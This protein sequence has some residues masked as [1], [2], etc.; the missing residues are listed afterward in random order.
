MISGKRTEPAAARRRILGKPGLELVEE[1]VYLLRQTPLATLALYFIGSLPFVFGVITFWAAMIQS[2]YAWQTL[3]DAA[4][5]LALLFVWMKVWQSRFCQHLMAQLQGDRVPR[6][7]PGCFLRSVSIQGL[8]Q[9]TG[10]IVLPVAA[11]L[12][13]PFG[14]VYAAYQNATVLDSG[15]Y[16]STRSLLRDA[17]AQARLWPRQNHVVIWLLSPFLLLLV[18]GVFLGLLP[19]INALSSIFLTSVLYLLAGILILALMPLSPFGLIVALNLGT[20][21]LF[22]VGLLDTLLGIK[23][24]FSTVPGAAL[25]S[26]FVAMVFGLAYLC[27]D[28][29]V[30]A[31]Y[32]LRCFYSDSLK[33]G[34]DLRVALRRYGNVSNTRGSV[35]HTPNRRYGSLLLLAVFGVALA[36]VMRSGGDVKAASEWRVAPEQIDRALDQELTHRR[37]TWRMP[38]QNI[39]RDDGL[40]RPILLR[41]KKKLYGYAEVIG[42]WLGKRFRSWFTPSPE[43]IAKTFRA[44]AAAAP[45][46]RWLLILLLVSLVAAF[47]LLTVRLWRQRRRAEPRLGEAMLPAA[48]DLED[49]KT[50]AADLPE[51]EWV[52]MAREL[53]G[54]GEYRLAI[55]ALHLAS[56]ARLAET[57]YLRLA[58][59]K[60]NAEYL[61]ELK[62]RAHSRPDVIPAFSGSTQI[63]EAVWY[64]GHDPAERMLHERMLSNL[65]Q[66]EPGA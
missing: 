9:A 63:Y 53:I 47:A 33:S 20:G 34:E 27:M 24:V 57:G 30:K 1:A 11:L 45:L 58:R 12:T 2:A 26:T 19:V 43:G 22:S 65:A 40:V 21:I 4:L 15:E 7:T 17:V 59:Y 5:G 8:F 55:R 25:N 49:E 6:W 28:P 16:L 14:W 61:R 48:P 36:A 44:L 10:F 23:T 41:I 35:S 32:V 62:R 3:P 31:A 42:R 60:S 39:E 13:I 66:L 56:L 46:L 51:E 18:A 37:Y 52:A 64:G 50:S 29:A 38:R 54:R